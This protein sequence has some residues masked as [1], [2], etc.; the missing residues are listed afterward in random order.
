M[1]TY[2]TNYFSKY[3][4]FKIIYSNKSIVISFFKLNLSTVYILIIRLLKSQIFKNKELL[5][6]FSY[7]M[8]FF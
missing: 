5:L 8:K 4:Y 7:Y 6:K 1:G 2:Y 3:I